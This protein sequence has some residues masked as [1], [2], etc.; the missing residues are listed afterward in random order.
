MLPLVWD[1]VLQQQIG[2]LADRA[3]NVF[4]VCTGSTLLAATERLD[5]R[6]ATTKKRLYDEVTPKRTLQ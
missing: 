2:Q 5:G 4:T 6:K 1:P 3:P